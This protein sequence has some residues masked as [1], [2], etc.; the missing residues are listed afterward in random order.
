MTKLIYTTNVTLDGYI[1]DENGAFDFFPVDD[2]V[3]AAHTDLLRSVGTFMYG[4]RLYEAMAVW[5]TNTDLA[6]Q[7]TLFA[8]FA[9]AWRAPNKI[10]YSRTLAAASTSNTRIES[11]FDPT[12]VLDIKVAAPRDLLIGGADLA[13]QAFKAGLVDEVQLYVLPLIV[14]GG[15]PGLP[16]GTRAELELLDE[17]RFG[18]GVVR[19]RYRLPGRA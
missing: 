12:A 10:V 11:G 15:K 3:F 7:S 5:E 1:E 16:T 2:E 17:H 13:A 18:N 14:G 6:A 9:A 8:D 4:R 19:L